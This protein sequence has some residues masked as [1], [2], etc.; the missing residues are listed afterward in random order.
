MV[1]G[2]RLES[3]CRGNCT[4]GSNPSLSANIHPCFHTVTGALKPQGAMNAS[5]S[6][7]GRDF[8]VLPM[9]PESDGAL[10]CPSSCPFESTPRARGG[11]E[12]TDHS[13]VL[14][15]VITQARF[16]GYQLRSAAQDPRRR[17]GSR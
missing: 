13:R 9:L 6:S 8:S 11:D 16:F 3:V 17:S 12:L 14:V 1:E 4:E 5:I 15:E 10:R 7:L 2:A